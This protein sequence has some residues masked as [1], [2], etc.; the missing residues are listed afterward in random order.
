MTKRSFIY[1][2]LLAQALYFGAYARLTAGKAGINSFSRFNMH[3][4][5][6]FSVIFPALPGGY[7]ITRG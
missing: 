4:G 3:G 2:V 6:S 1:S 7:L 5:Q